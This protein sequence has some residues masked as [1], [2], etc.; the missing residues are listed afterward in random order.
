SEIRL[1]E[2]LRRERDL[3][4]SARIAEHSTRASAASH[5]LPSESAP[6]PGSPAR[7]DSSR[8]SPPEPGQ[9]ADNAHNSASRA[10]PRLHRL[11]TLHHFP[12]KT[13]RPTRI[14][15]LPRWPSETSCPSPWSS[16]ARK[17]LSSLR[18]F[19]LRA[20]SSSRFQQKKSCGTSKRSP[21]QS[22]A[23]ARSPGRKA[24]QMFSGSRLLL[25]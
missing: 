8:A 17:S 4:S 24:A 13:G 1:R 10:W 18:G 3:R 16:S 15:P 21:P 14:S 19:G 22:A 23:S 6:P 11:E 25:G 20:A 9:A 7:K 2:N 12:H 5:C